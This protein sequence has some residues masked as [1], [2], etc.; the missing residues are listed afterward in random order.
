[1]TGPEHDLLALATAAPDD[2]EAVRGACAAVQ[3]WGALADWAAAHGLAGVILAEARRAGATLPEGPSSRLEGWLAEN[4]AREARHREALGQALGALHSAG[5]RAVSL[6][7]LVLGERLYGVSA[8]RPTTDIDLLVSDADCERA[9]AVLTRA[10]WSWKL[11]PT[12]RYHRRHHQHLHLLRGGAPMV[13]LHF[14]VLTG[15]GTVVPAEGFLAR[16][17]PYR[18]GSGPTFV[19]APEDEVLY[20]AVHAAGHLLVRLGW[21]YDL[22]LLIRASPSLAWEEVR[23]RAEELGV[24]RAVAFALGA[25]RS[26]GAEVPLGLLVD[27]GFR[28]MSAERV[29]RLA[30][31]KAQP[32]P[33]YTAGWIAFHAL[34]ADTPR[35]A[36]RHLAHHLGRVARRRARR[37]L[38]RLVPEEWSG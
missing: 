22:K 34:L 15:F 24:W 17:L 18:S 28:D 35:G 26:L 27:P 4:R 36:A 32:S 16:A 1:M 38:A 33:G 19:L 10:G 9:T 6:K 2:Q 31:R 25:A 14:R 3:D 5:I 30:L 7:G 29:R 12:E 13:E 8:L 21:L 37:H 11:D 20:L 23:R